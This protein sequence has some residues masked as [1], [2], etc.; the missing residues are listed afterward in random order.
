[1]QR[2]LCKISHFPSAK[3]CE[4]N[5]TGSLTRW[6][7]NRSL[8]LQYVPSQSVRRSKKIVRWD[9]DLPLRLQYVPSQSVRRGKKSPVGTLTCHCGY[10]VVDVFKPISLL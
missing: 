9:T 6:D 1:M 3:F 10:S 2:S 5:L 4:A 7:T 8:R